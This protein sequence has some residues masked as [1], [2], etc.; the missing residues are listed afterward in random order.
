MNELMSHVERAV[1][2]VKAT[3]RRKLEMREELL[4]HLRGVFDEE[5][6]RSSD[7]IAAKQV[8]IERFGPAEELS[9]KLTATVPWYDPIL[10][11]LNPTRY[12]QH[13][14]FWPVT[15]WASVAYLTLAVLMLGVM[16]RIFSGITGL[17][18]LAVIV[19]TMAIMPPVYLTLLAMA[20]TFHGVLRHRK[21]PWRAILYGVGLAGY[22]LSSGLTILALDG[23]DV[24]RV[25]WAITMSIA[26]PM[27]IAVTAK[28]LGK[29]ILKEEEILAR[30]DR[31]EEIELSDG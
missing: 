1:R 21:A 29:E 15:L 16:S 18:N 2:P 30:L 14:S 17:E 25:T 8:A 31:W 26:T 11:W 5:L 3:R 28:Q 7:E 9:Q 4:S 22:L 23:L 13:I 24:P 19:V 12:R 27:I 10:P 20:G 6:A